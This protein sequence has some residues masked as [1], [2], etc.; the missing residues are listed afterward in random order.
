MLNTVMIVNNDQFRQ[1]FKLFCEL[2]PS[3]VKELKLWQDNGAYC[4]LHVVITAAGWLS[5]CGASVL[6]GVMWW[7]SKQ[8]TLG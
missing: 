4:V 8:F 5:D 1:E 3:E 2:I 7:S 6:R